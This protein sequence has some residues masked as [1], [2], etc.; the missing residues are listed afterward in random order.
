[1]VDVEVFPEDNKAICKTD[2]RKETY[3][4][5]KD[6]S[7]FITFEFHVSKGQL[8]EILRGKFTSIEKAVK[9]FEEWDRKIRHSQAVKDEEFAKN[10]EKRRA[11]LHSKAS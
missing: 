10:R 9:A 5:C 6:R 3:E 7:G 4:I 11:E 8:P 1:M 2:K